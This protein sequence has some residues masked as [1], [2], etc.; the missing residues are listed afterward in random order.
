MRNIDTIEE[1]STSDD[2][3][4]LT[5]V[6][7]G[8][9]VSYAEYTKYNLSLVFDG[10]GLIRQAE[11]KTNVYDI[12]DYD[13]T[14][15]SLV[16]G[17]MPTGSGSSSLTTERGYKK[18][19][20]SKYD[21]RDY[22]VNDYTVITGESFEGE[23]TSFIGGGEVNNG[24]ILS[25]TYRSSELKP[26]KLNPRPVQ[27]V[28]D[29]E[30]I[31]TLSGSSISVKKEGEFTVVF[32]N[33]LGDLKE[34]TFTSV[35]PK[36]R[37]ISATMSSTTIFVGGNATV[38]AEITPE[39]ALQDYTVSLKEGSECTVDITEN[40]DGTFNVFGKTA[41]NGTLIV[42]SAE[43]SSIYEEVEF[44]VVTPPTYEDLYQFITQNTVKGQIH[45]SY[46]DLYVYVNFND[47]GTG[48]FRVDD[49]Y[50]GITY[51]SVVAFTYTLD[52]DTLEFTI[53]LTDDSETSNS[54]TLYSVSAISNSSLEI[55]IDRYG[56]PEDPCVATSIGEKVDLETYR[57]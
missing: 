4:Y 18:P 31:A 17:A 28:S 13:E 41:G 8:E 56:R 47:D 14:T 39:Q 51:G 34:L 9:N 46:E 19:L 48:E 1:Q 3:K 52:K 30:E 2:N 54:Y 40:E 42:T 50:Y 12:D 21:V 32:D 36:A 37:R 33:G 44:S 45:Y 29:V 11:L 35:R 22:V 16:E 20:D 43:D 7:S 57:E 5:I 27:I 26:M 24:S 25:F 53:A 15:E 10:D 38:S 49:D 55:T 6:T 23:S